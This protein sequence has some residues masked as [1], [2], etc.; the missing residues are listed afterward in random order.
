MNV[1]DGV[2]T[3]KRRDGRW[4][5]VRIDRIVWVSPVWGMIVGW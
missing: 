5:G 4:D 2:K 3:K 1:R